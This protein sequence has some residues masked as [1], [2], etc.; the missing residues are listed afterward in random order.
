MFV[1]ANDKAEVRNAEITAPESLVRRWTVLPAKDRN[2]CGRSRSDLV[3]V[4]RAPYR[5]PLCVL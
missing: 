1:V 4:W 5:L 2:Y 3:T